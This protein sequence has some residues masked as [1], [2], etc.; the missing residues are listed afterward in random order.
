LAAGHI[1]FAGGDIPAGRIVFAEILE[2]DSPW[3]YEEALPKVIATL[4]KEGSE[5][6]KQTVRLIFKNKRY[7]TIRGFRASLVNQCAEAGI[8]DGYL[9]YLPLLDIKG[10]SIGNISYSKD[11]VVGEMIAK[12][13]IDKLAPMD[14]EL[15][16]IEKTYP[17]A[18]DQI[19]PLK[20]W[21]KVKAKALGSP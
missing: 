17:K 11:T 8:G 18:A 2:N 16:H 1:L 7:D 6:S 20:E 12:E 15:L 10:N 9:G 5:S 13:I 4:L 3:D 14:P 21:L 19:A